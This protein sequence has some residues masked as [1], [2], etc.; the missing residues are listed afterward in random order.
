[1]VFHL[2]SSKTSSFCL[3]N[4]NQIV[5]F[6]LPIPS[7]IISRGQS[8]SAVQLL[9]FTFIILRLFPKLAWWPSLVIMS[10]C[11]EYTFVCVS[12]GRPSVKESNSSECN[13]IH[14]PCRH[15][16]THSP[17]SSSIEWRGAF[18][19][20]FV[21]VAVNQSILLHGGSNA[22]CS[23]VENSR[24][25]HCQPSNGTIIGGRAIKVAG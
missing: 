17:S 24:I 25:F 2:K 5:L 9:I 14:S 18:Y 6:L 19:S 13:L 7:L 4:Q 22:K 20:P 12:I 15:S 1:M 16:L 8:N 23:H 21:S 11:L 3:N 10:S